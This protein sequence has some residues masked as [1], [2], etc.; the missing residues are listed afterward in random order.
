MSLVQWHTLAWP[1][2]DL[3]IIEAQQAV[4]DRFS[5]EVNRAREKISHGRWI[6]A[7]LTASTADIVG[8]FDAD[9]VP[10]NGEIVGRCVDFV[11]KEG[12][13]VGL[14]QVSNH[15]GDRNHIFAAPAFFLI[16]RLCWEEMGRPTFEA[17]KRTRLR[18]GGPNGIYVRRRADVAENVSYAAERL[19]IPYRA[20]YPT[21]F[22]SDPP[23]SIWH[24]ANYGRYG[25]GTTYAGGIYHLY[26]SRFNDNVELFV[27]RCRDIVAGRFSTD[28]MIPHS[29][30]K[31]LISLS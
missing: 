25:V 10:C 16:R 27:R 21:H 12:S 7:T 14:A 4:F 19:R 9:C 26:N 30:S 18:F 1:N 3:E 28:G 24:L 22:E 29:P 17:I 2:V 20:L 6:D 31:S 13:F 23:G 8:F 5:I 11:E 15:I